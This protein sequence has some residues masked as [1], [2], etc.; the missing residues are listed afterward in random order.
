MPAELSGVICG[1]IVLLPH[2]YVICMCVYVNVVA[3]S[4]ILLDR[5]DHVFC[6]KNYHS[7]VIAIWCGRSS[8]V[9]NGHRWPSV[10]DV[11]S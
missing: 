11:L 7:H 1:G 4:E 8:G 6:I 3:C 9:A 5:A 2:V 10:S